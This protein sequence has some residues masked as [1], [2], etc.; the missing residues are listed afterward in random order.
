MTAAALLASCCDA[1][2]EKVDKPVAD[3]SVAEKSQ[4]AQTDEF[5]RAIEEVLENANL[6]YRPPR[7]MDTMGIT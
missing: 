6:K 7:K 3:K 5:Y 2:E 4:A 1:K